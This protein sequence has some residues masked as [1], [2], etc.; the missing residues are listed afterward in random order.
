MARSL[1]PGYRYATPIELI[2]AGKSLTSRQVVTP[3]GDLIARRQAENIDAQAR[4][5]E[6]K[7]HQREAAKSS[8]ISDAVQGYRDSW[9]RNAEKQGLDTRIRGNVDYQNFRRELQDLDRSRAD[10]LKTMG[11]KAGQKEYKKQY[12]DIYLKYGLITDAQYKKYL[13]V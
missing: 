12:S 4:G 10:L 3:S 9:R 1:P 11:K 7:E 13:G 6:S 5:Y 2:E 8:G